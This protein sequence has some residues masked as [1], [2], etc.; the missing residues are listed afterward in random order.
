MKRMKKNVNEFSVSTQGSEI[1]PT[2]L[3]YTKRVSDKT[4]RGYLQEPLSKKKKFI[5]MILISIAFITTKADYT[6][7]I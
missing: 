7:H 5:H 1:Y 6:R 2:G 4:E 3:L